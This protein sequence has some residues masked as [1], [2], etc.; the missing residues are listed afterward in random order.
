MRAL[1]IASYSFFSL[2]TQ[3]KVYSSLKNDDVGEEVIS[4]KKASFWN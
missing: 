2:H 3:A 1:L 4:H